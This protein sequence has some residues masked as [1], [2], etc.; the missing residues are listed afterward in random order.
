MAVISGVHLSAL[1]WLFRPRVVMGPL[2]LV[3]EAGG[4]PAREMAAGTVELTSR[5]RVGWDVGCHGDSGS[6]RVIDRADLQLGLRSWQ[7]RARWRLA[8]GSRPDVPVCNTHLEP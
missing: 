1:T 5:Q 8:L 4:H 7:G 2:T 3:S 6:D